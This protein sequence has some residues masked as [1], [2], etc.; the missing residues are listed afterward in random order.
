MLPVHVNLKN[1]KAY[2]A[3]AGYADGE[4]NVSERAVAVTWKGHKRHG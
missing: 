4:D 3:L 2:Y 1:V